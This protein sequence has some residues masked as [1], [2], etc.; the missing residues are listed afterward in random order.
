MTLGKKIFEERK[1]RGLSQE[2]LAEKLNVSPQAVSK[3]ENDQSCPDIQLLPQLA[4]LFDTTVDALLSTEENPT[5]VVRQ[6]PPEQRRPLEELTLR[7]RVLSA[8][9]DSVK[10]N[11]PASLVKVALEI[12][13]QLP[14]V[15][16]NEA[17]QGVDL[18]QV[19]QLVEAGM[20]GTLVEVE[21]ADG[22]LVT[23]SVE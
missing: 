15:S 9:G 16:G 22:C 20:I 8:T 10:V 13:M 4:K 7:V 5:P 3:W 14:Q 1:T 11:L 17:L 2:A 12:G 21:S 23:V 19:M 6:L 18:A